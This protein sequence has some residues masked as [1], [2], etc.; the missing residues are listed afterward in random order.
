MKLLPVFK[1]VITGMLHFFSKHNTS[2]TPQLVFPTK[3]RPEYEKGRGK[4]E[5]TVLSTSRKL[6]FLGS[7]F[8]SKMKMV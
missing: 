7:F 3:N 6:H 5:T 1:K 2:A 8:V 4:K